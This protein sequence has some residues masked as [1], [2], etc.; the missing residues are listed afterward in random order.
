[1]PLDSDLRNV[2]VTVDRYQDIKRRLSQERNK[3]MKKVK[4]AT[5]N[6]N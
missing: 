3:K 1:M 2:P 5:R 6:S 4:E